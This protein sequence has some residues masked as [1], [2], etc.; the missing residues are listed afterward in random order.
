VDS[1]EDAHPK[2]LDGLQAG[3]S[4][5]Q[6]IEAMQ[7]QGAQREANEHGGENVEDCGFH[8]GPLNERQASGVDVSSDQRSSEGS[9]CDAVV[10][11]SVCA[12]VNRAR[13]LLGAD[14]LISLDCVCHVVYS[15]GLCE[16]LL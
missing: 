9:D 11:R 5:E 2:A 6:G 13:L 14:E 7:Q 1:G 15:S 4:I 16:P 3:L 8:D 10:L 12:S